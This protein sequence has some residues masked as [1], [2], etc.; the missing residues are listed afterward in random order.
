[1]QSV[2]T[3]VLDWLGPVNCNHLQSDWTTGGVGPF[4]TMDSEGYAEDADFS[5][6]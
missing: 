5:A 6:L 1:M 4:E 3:L 2:R